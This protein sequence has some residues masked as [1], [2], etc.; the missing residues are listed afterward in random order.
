MRTFVK[1]INISICIAVSI[2]FTAATK[3]SCA[4]TTPLGTPASLTT[5]EK[6]LMANAAYSII[7]KFAGREET[8]KTNKPN[9]LV[10]YNRLYVTLYSN[11]VVRGCQ[12]G[13]RGGK[14]PGDL[15]L[16]L[17]EATQKAIDEKAFGGPFKP[18]EVD[19]AF[20][21]VSILYDRNSLKKYDRKSIQSGIEP[22][23]H[24]VGVSKDGKGALFLES[25]P[26]KKGYNVWQTLRQLCIQAGL[27]EKAY[28]EPGATIYRYQSESFMA[29]RTNVI[30]LIRGSMLVDGSAVNQK[31]LADSLES[32]Y[33]YFGTHLLDQGG[34]FDYEYDASRDK[35]S[36]KNN[37]I[38]QMAALWIAAK[39]ANFLKRDDLNSKIKDS[40]DHYT[41]QI[42]KS[43]DGLSYIGIDENPKI[44]Y[45]AFIILALS[46][47]ANNDAASLTQSILAQ[48][49]LDMQQPD[50][51]FKT[52]FLEGGENGIDYY[53]GEAM[54]AL[55][56]LYDRSK[57]KRREYV[58]A[59]QKALPYYRQ[60]WQ[61]NKNTAFVPWQTQ[62]YYL[63]HKVTGDKE[64]ADFIFEMND[65]LVDNHQ[66]LAP[67]YP[68]EL[69]GFPKKI[70]FGCRTSAYLEGLIDAQDLARKVGDTTRMEKYR[71]AILLGLRFIMQTQF[72]S[73]NTY[74]VPKPWKALGGFKKSLFENDIRIDYV[75]HAANAIMK[76]LTLESFSFDSE[77]SLG[78][79]NNNIGDDGDGSGDNAGG[80]SDPD[81]QTQEEA[82]AEDNA[83]W[84]DSGNGDE[85]PSADD[86][87]DDSGNKG[88]DQGDDDSVGD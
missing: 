46:E 4:D 66:L 41:L 9:I 12:S 5:A 47:L 22:G 72:D 64:L 16:D 32:A 3:A 62:A 74:Y 40:V 45:N 85:Q 77:N 56:T 69:G 14:N 28:Q 30:P 39:A 18:E 81:A 55:I 25:I 38:R 15:W 26:V 59:L 24:A 2:W 65:W 36:D 43:E 1:A 19:D 31:Q 73:N 49:L 44:A 87:I 48:S 68:D 51:S 76:T 21:V 88:K 23:I 60:Y 82:A 50:G 7:D 83:S 42:K 57:N 53:P 79:G 67:K 75:Q 61:G 29:T 71:K 8:T 80:L 58:E 6:Q 78:A 33:G 20:I 17:E 70:P 27:P 13:S 86:D 37:H 10:K 11:G 34:L 84:D 54:L 52:M 35:L 63:L